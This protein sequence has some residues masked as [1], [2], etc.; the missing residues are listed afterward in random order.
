MRNQESPRLLG[1]QLPA[2]TAPSVPVHQTPALAN[3]LIKASLHCALSLC[4]PPLIGSVGL[5]SHYPTD[6]KTHQ[7]AHLSGIL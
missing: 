5:F 4:V 1:D 6:G 3:A 7:D 2:V